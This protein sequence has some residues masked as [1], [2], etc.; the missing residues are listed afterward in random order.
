MRVCA[1]HLAVAPGH[2]ARAAPL[3]LSCEP[4]SHQWPGFLLIWVCENAL[5]R[6]CF[7][8]AAAT[9]CVLTTCGCAATCLS[10]PYYD[11]ALCATL[12]FVGHT[13]VAHSEPSYGIVTSHSVHH[14]WY[15]AKVPQRNEDKI[16]Y[17][18]QRPEL[19]VKTGFIC[20]RG[21]SYPTRKV[22]RDVDEIHGY[23]SWR[24][25]VRV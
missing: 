3:G 4:W 23:A 1:G 22:H 8:R 21:S 18:Q 16:A 13:A 9:W 20:H 12:L 14:S 19:A 24:A 17:K 11:S 10:A 6:Y 25:R 15:R 7:D 5:T 2:H